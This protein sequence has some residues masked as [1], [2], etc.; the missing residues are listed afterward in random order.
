MLKKSNPWFTSLWTLQEAYLRPDMLL[1]SKDWKLL[2]VSQ[3]YPVNLLD[4]ISIV[5]FSREYTKDGEGLPSLDGAAE[6]LE[7]CGLSDLLVASP[8]NILHMGSRRE[9]T[10]CRAEAIMSVLNAIEWFQVD[11]PNPGDAYLINGLYPRE[12]LQEVRER[13]GS[14]EFFTS[15][16]NTDSTDLKIILEKI[17][18][19]T[20][21]SE[22]LV[23]RSSLLPFGSNSSPLPTTVEPFF[24]RHP[25][26]SSWAITADGSV[27]IPE[28]ALLTILADDV[29]ILL[30]AGES[31]N[32]DIEGP[33]KSN[34]WK[35]IEK[36]NVNLSQ[37]LNG[38]VPE[39]PNYAV[40]THFS[41]MVVFGLI[42]KEV[43]PG[44]LIKVGTFRTDED[45]DIWE[46]LTEM[47]YCQ[48][49]WNVL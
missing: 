6:L 35:K 27:Y 17:A 32:C 34:D 44:Q 13:I 16:L 48:V 33:H 9:C 47:K 14:V 40:C 42:L 23:V 36:E 18:N 2:G 20:W 37:W 31:N 26:V 7:I 22:D 3:H 1:A 15:A 10:G 8:T 49:D 29:S 46:Y 4:F 38:Y 21:T 28:V 12:F 25:T 30:G 5:M 43:S 39:M 24:V 19:R 45:S 11:N 41:P